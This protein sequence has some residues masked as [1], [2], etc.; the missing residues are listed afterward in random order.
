MDEFE[1]G[2]WVY[3]SDWCYGVIVSIEDDIA[4]VE[5][6][7]FGGGGTWSFWLD[8]LTLANEED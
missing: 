4:V 6:E 2:D 3:A 7:T 8:E 5:F 1:V